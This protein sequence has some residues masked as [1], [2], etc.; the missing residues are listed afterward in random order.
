MSYVYY[1]TMTNMF[2]AVV[3][4]MH[5][6]LNILTTFVAWHFTVIPN[7]SWCCYTCKVGP[8]H[9]TIT[10]P[11]P[12]ITRPRAFSIITGK[13]VA[14]AFWN[15]ICDINFQELNLIS[16]K[17]YYCKYFGNV[18]M[19]T[20]SYHHIYIFHQDMFPKHYNLHYWRIL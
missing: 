4:D 18:V 3:F 17:I 5:N 20:F 1:L 12:L 8:M 6:L 11:R 16:R 13:I 10:I 15:R 2:E 14:A 7:F 19:A 9:I